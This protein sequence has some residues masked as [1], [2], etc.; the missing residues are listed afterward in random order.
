[1]KRFVGQALI[2]RLSGPLFPI[3][4]AVKVKHTRLRRCRD[5][6]PAADRALYVALAKN[7]EERLSNASGAGR[8]CPGVKLPGHIIPVLSAKAHQRTPLRKVLLGKQ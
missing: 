7:S 4:N 5:T 8:R 1:M 3:A 2:F 6:D